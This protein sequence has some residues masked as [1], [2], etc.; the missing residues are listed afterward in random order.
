YYI[1]ST[2]D[3]ERRLAQ[4]RNGQ[5]HSTHRLGNPVELVAEL[6]LPT[7]AEARAFERE[8]KRK[9]NPRLALLLLEQRRRASVGWSSPESVRGWF[10]VQVRAGPPILF[11]IFELRFSSRRKA[12][13]SSQKKTQR[14]D[15]RCYGR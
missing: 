1:G 13:R 8:L 7:I 5:V 15:V 11:W 12:Q 6:R 14:S 10:S 4:H 3:L 9:K 2:A